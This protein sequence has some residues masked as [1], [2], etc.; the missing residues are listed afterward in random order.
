MLK[1]PLL[2]V[3]VVNYNF[4]QYVLETLESIRQQSY[5]DFERIFID[6]CSTD[7]SVAIAKRWMAEQNVPWKVIVN[8]KNMGVC[9][10]LNKA[11]NLA[12]GKYISATAGDDIFMPDKLKIQLEHMESAPPDVC[13]VYSNAYIINERGT[14]LDKNFIE[15][16]NVK[17]YPSGKIFDTLLV[18]NFIPAMSVLLRKDCFDDIGG[19]DEQLVY[20]DYD[21]WLRLASKYKFLYSDYISVQYRVKEKSLSTSIDWDLPNVKILLKHV[22]DSKLAL[23]KL[24][25]IALRA[26]RNKKQ[27][28]LESLTRENISDTYIRRLLFLHRNKIPAKYGHRL[29]TL[30]KR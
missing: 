9:A 1:Q 17:G 19:F 23:Q 25:E 8:E 4:Q 29:L 26:Y 12:S 11:F 6:D 18:D 3:I 13:A 2:S 21:M 22:S 30:A 27:K 7:D 14:Q 5:G 28:V 10:T 15:R 16:R 24:R 20:E